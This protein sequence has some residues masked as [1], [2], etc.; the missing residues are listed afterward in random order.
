M[1][2]ITVTHCIEYKHNGYPQMIWLVWF[3]FGFSIFFAGSWS[4][5]LKQNE[6]Q[7]KTIGT[8]LLK[9]MQ[10]YSFYLTAAYTSYL[11]DNLAV[12][13]SIFWQKYSFFYASVDHH[14]AQPTTFNSWPPI[15]QKT[16][17]IIVVLVIHE[18]LPWLYLG[19]RLISQLSVYT[20]LLVRFVALLE[21]TTS[22]LLQ[23][24][25]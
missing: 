3:F 7:N 20:L 1:C 11:S 19:C 6:N 5:H 8:K 2:I 22:L 21:I 25:R 4:W 16:F 24:N 15:L 10:H 14:N 13:I 9:S 18:C 12:L 17:V 23:Y